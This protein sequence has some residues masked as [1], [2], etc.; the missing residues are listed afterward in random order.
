MMHPKPE[1]AKNGTAAGKRYLD[2][3]RQLPC[4][5]CGA[6]P[7]SAHHVICGRY[8]QS[9][10]SDFDAIPLCYQHHQ[11]ERGIHTDQAAWVARHGPDTRYS[12]PTRRRIG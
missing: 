2:A 4:C 12:E 11:G 7:S 1:K 6:W 3:V 9:K 8:S 5:I 10:S